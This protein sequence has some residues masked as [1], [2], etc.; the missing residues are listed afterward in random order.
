MSELHNKGAER[1]FL[2]VVN[3]IAGRRR[4]EFLRRTLENLHRAGLDVVVMETS[5]PA[6]AERIAHEAAHGDEV[7]DAIVAAG[8]DGT[9]NEVVNGLDGSPLPLG[10]IPMGTANVLANELGIGGWSGPVSDVLINGPA[11]PVHMGVIDGRRFLMMAGIGYDARTVARVDTKI[12]Y[13]WGKLA[14]ALAGFAEW[15]DGA[16]ERYHVV[17]D[18]KSHEAAWVIVSNSRC[19]AGRY[20]VAPKASLAAPSLQVCVMPG[21]SR[22]DLFRY[23]AAIGRGRLDREKDVEIIEATDVHIPDAAHTQVEIDGDYHGE[24]PLRISLAR[25]TLNLIQPA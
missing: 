13:R 24:G 21:H 25:E 3:P 6:D 17:I 23:L 9:I 16:R 1:R 5:G 18:G 14:Y 4:K 22:W 2:V 12:K 19:Y 10:I 8:G 7:F 15:F 11:R 20:V